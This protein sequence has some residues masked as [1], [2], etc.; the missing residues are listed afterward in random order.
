MKSSTC[1]WGFVSYFLESFVHFLVLLP[2]NVSSASHILYRTDISPLG[3]HIG[4]LSNLTLICSLQFFLHLLS[5]PPHHWPYLNPGNKDLR[6]KMRVTW[7]MQWKTNFSNAF[8]A[9]FH[10]N[11]SSLFVFGN[12]EAIESIIFLLY[13]KFFLCVM[14]LCV[15]EGR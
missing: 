7:K 14:H 12:T 11:A 9:Y 13:M 2:P 10:L 15:W 3:P 1:C 6:R 8:R 5:F 4:S